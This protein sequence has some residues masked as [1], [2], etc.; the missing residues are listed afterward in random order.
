MDKLQQAAMDVKAKVASAMPSGSGDSSGPRDTQLYETLQVP[1][2]ASKSDIKSAYKE[3]KQEVGGHPPS[4]IARPLAQASAAAGP[5]LP[6]QASSA[7]TTLVDHFE[8]LICVIVYRRYCRRHRWRSM[9]WAGKPR[10]RRRRTS[11]RHTRCLD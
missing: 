3:A 7:S 2:D 1:E 9:P 6:S 5:D 4:G 8:N 10:L 11:R